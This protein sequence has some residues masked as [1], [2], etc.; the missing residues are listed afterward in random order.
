MH[1]ADGMSS[2]PTMDKSLGML[3]DSS[4]AL[5]IAPIAVRSFEQTTAVGRLDKDIK[6]ETACAPP[7][8]V[9]S[10]SISISGRVAK[11]ISSM[12]A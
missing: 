10:P 7:T 5:C 2:I 3:T 6:A 12:H 9:L 11:S 8:I 4:Q 1:C